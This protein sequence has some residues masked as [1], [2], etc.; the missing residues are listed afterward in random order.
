MFKSYNFFYKGLFFT[1]PTNF[2][3]NVRRVICKYEKWTN[4]RD[5]ELIYSLFSSIKLKFDNMAH[6][7]LCAC[8]SKQR[9]THI[10]GFFRQEGERCNPKLNNN[11]RELFSFHI[12]N[13]R[14]I[15]ISFIIVVLFFFQNPRLWKYT[16]LPNQLHD[17]QLLTIL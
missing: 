9:W 4:A 16:Q 3:S 17:V 6:K 8:F 5:I 14:A 15:W 12:K 7:V 2:I 1:S 11:F 13:I 10:L